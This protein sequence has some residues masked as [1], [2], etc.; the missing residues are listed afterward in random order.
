[1]KIKTALC[2]SIVLIG[3]TLVLDVANVMKIRIAYVK[4]NDVR[5]WND[6]V[7]AVCEPQHQIVFIKTHKTA[8]TTTCTIILRYGYIRNLSFALPPVSQRKFPTTELFTAD[9]VEEYS[10]G[11]TN[12]TFNIIPYHFRY[13]RKELNKVVPGAMYITILREPTAQFESAFGYFEVAKHLD[14]VNISNPLAVFM[15]SPDRYYSDEREF[16]GK[17]QLRNGMAFD[18]GLSDDIHTKHDKDIEREVA[19]LDRELNLVMLADYYEESLI[20]LKKLLCWEWRDVL[21]IPKGHRSESLK[22]ALNQTLADSIQKWNSVDVALYNHFNKSFWRKIGEYGPTFQ[23]DL[24]EFRK[25]QAKFYDECV[26]SVI[27]YK[28]RREDRL[29]LKQGASHYCE[30][31]YFRVPAYNKMIRL[32]KY[33][34]ANNPS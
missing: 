3:I 14:L 13:N 4:G 29:T 6:P 16:K 34:E 25:R 28:D 10:N 12:A 7:L 23:R 32:K 15:T 33:S 22:Y 8:S 9:K 2:I 19:R 21:Y 27:S 31:S 17:T 5:F 24:S 30:L 11:I 26:D 18:L 1:M 20:L